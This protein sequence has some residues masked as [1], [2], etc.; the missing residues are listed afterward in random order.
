MTGLLRELAAG[1]VI[2]AIDPGKVLNRVWITSG[3]GLLSDPVSL[4]TSRVGLDRLEALVT[5]C[6]SQPHS[7]DRA[8]LVAWSY[9]GFVVADYIR[10]YGDQRIVGLNLV[11]GAVMLKPPAFDHIG[12]G[13]LENAEDA[14]AADLGVNIDAIQRFVRACTAHPL[15]QD[16]W[17]TALCW[18][19]VVAP[20]VRGALISR[21]ID[22]DDVLSNLSLPVLV[23]H[24][25]SDTVVLP[26]MAQHVLDVCGTAEP[27]WYDDVGHMPFPGRRS[28]VRPRTR[29]VRR[30]RAG[31]P[32]HDA[33]SLP[34]PVGQR[35]LPAIRLRRSH[36]VS[37][38]LDAAGRPA[39]ARDHAG[40]PHR[41]RAAAPRGRRASLRAIVSEAR[42]AEPASRCAMSWRGRG[43]S[44]VRR[45]E[46]L[47]EEPDQAGSG[48]RDAPSR[49]VRRAAG[50]S[51]YG[52]MFWLR[53]NRLSGSYFRLTSTRRS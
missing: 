51:A 9:G 2:V 49:R 30:P 45:A 5:S 3:D 11:G 10:A 7:L 15:S 21:E 52:L 40:L 39:I 16:D 41:S 48:D 46:A 35:A 25:R 33:E 12:P 37:P 47:S 17:T 8:V 6:G 20:E 43:C 22:S 32:V 13:F 42:V 4:P 28:A 23:T 14:C 27:S 50:G 1:R 18:N 53:W 24:G 31:P 44:R 29:R 36:D 26:S 38:A 34:L 19:M